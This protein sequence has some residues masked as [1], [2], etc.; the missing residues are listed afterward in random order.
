MSM[1]PTLKYLVFDEDKSVINW[2]AAPLVKHTATRSFSIFFA[3]EEQKGKIKAPKKYFNT[4]DA[5][6]ATTTT[7]ATVYNL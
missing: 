1:W 6:T 7:S 2:P 5:S 4:G 3:F